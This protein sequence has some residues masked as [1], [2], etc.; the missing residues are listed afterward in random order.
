MF[1]HLKFIHMIQTR[2]LGSQSTNPKTTK[3]NQKLK[4]TINLRIKTNSQ[5]AIDL[6]K[7]NK[8]IR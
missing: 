6:D 3:E 2:L 5:S 4:I 7:K 1:K 8:A